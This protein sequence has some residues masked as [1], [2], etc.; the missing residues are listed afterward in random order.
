MCGP[1]KTRL[2]FLI[3]FHGANIF[4][5]RIAIAQAMDSVDS[6]LESPKSQL[7]NAPKIKSISH[8]IDEISQDE[9]GLN[10]GYFAFFWLY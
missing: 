5:M 4:A 2:F 9:N 3:F 6:A 8:L 10:L 7:S 1:S